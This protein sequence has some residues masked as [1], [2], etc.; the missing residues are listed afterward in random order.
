MKSKEEIL[1]KIRPYKY[2]N[3]LVTVKDAY[4]AMEQLQAQHE[5]EMEG[6]LNWILD[7]SVDG[8][9]HIEGGVIIMFERDEDGIPIHPNR[10][11]T[12]Q[13]LLA[14]FRGTKG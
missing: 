5:I 6:L 8:D 4:E 2:L 14:K 11:A 1:Q 12:F 10:G 3:D 9:I 13:Y 7:E